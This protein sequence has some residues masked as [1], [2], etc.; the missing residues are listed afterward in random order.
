MSLTLMRTRALSA[1]R[2]GTGFFSDER[3]AG[4]LSNLFA[5]R[6]AEANDFVPIGGIARGGIWC[7]RR[8]ERD[9]NGGG[10]GENGAVAKKTARAC[11]RNGNDG[12]AG[13]DR[14]VKRAELERADAVFGNEG[15]FGKNKNGFATAQDG[16]HFFD[17]FAA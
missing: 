11:E 5:D 8:R 2:T 15:A 7:G 16:F 14:S 17:G 13:G 1:F 3:L 10:A 6:I 9:G 4:I 12:N